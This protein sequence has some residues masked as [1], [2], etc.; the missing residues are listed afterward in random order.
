V[1][2]AAGFML[3]LQDRRSSASSNASRPV[4]PAGR[5]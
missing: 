2:P 5:G 1:I 3:L 4:W